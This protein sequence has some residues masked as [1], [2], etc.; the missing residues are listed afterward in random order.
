MLSESVLWGSVQGGDRVTNWDTRDS[1]SKNPKKK[2]K[3]TLE[4]YDKK[5][6]KIP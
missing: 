4:E 2:K 5:K 1:R 3:K 6:K